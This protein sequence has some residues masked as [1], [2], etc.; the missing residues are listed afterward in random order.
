MTLYI[1]HFQKKCT[2][3]SPTF[4]FKL[5]PSLHHLVNFILPRQRTHLWFTFVSCHCSR[6]RTTAASLLLTSILT[7][8]IVAVTC[9]SSTSRACTLTPSALLKFQCT[10]R[11]SL[12][13]LLKFQCSFQVSVHFSNFISLIEFRCTFPKLNCIS[14]LHMLFLHFTCN[15]YTSHA[16]RLLHMQF[17]K[18]HA[19]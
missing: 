17:L 18:S 16:N 7:I 15:S 12:G 4:R 19:I 9:N 5:R 8:V 14:Q 10:Y 6:G 1:A 13:A 11:S 2:Y 3:Y